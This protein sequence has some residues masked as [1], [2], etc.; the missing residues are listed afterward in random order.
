MAKQH[1]VRSPLP[2]I[3]YR[4]LALHEEDCVQTG[5]KVKKGDVIGVIEVMKSYYEVKAEGDGV[6]ERFL[7][8][9]GKDVEVGQAIALIKGNT[10]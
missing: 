10:T 5:D 4:K 7:V 1:K 2:G 6:V 8:D 9:H 3:F